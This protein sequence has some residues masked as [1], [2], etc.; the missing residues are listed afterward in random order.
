MQTPEFDRDFIV[1]ESNRMFALI[2]ADGNAERYRG[3]RTEQLVGEVIDYRNASY[4]GTDFIIEGSD[5]SS[6]DAIS[7]FKTVD[8]GAE[9]RR[10]T[11]AAFTILAFKTHLIGAEYNLTAINPSRRERQPEPTWNCSTWTEAFDR[12]VATATDIARLMVDSI[13]RYS[14]RDSRDYN[15]AT[16]FFW[17]M[18][19]D[20]AA[21]MLERGYEDIEDFL[22]EAN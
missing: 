4:P 14:L 5:I 19:G 22:P 12:K 15:K 1:S 13:E 11:T 10:V 16:I 17:K 21:R 18:I 3:N 6:T 9:D 7:L 2:A 20:S 8:I